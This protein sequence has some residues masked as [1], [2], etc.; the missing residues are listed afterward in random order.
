MNLLFI[1]PGEVGGSEPLL[2]NLARAIAPKVELTVFA[3]RGFSHAYPRLADEAEIVE[4]PWTRSA[5]GLR[6]ASEN[7]WL[8]AQTRRRKLNLVHHGGGTAPILRNGATAVTVHD[9]QYFHYP[10]NFVKVKRTWLEFAVPRAVKK[11]NAVCVPSD[12]VRTD[13]IQNLG[14]DGRRVH[15]IPFGRESLF[16]EEPSSAQDVAA[17]YHLERPYFYYPARTYPHKNHRML[18]E[19]FAPLADRAD[20]ILTG[21]PWFR[22]TSIESAVRNA[23]LG[24]KVR[25]LG[26]VPRRDLAGLY[27][28]SLALVFPSSFEGFGAPLVEAFSL[29]TPVIASDVTSIPEVAG[30]A[31]ILLPPDDPEAW[32]ESMD[33]LIEDP[34]LRR[35]LSRRGLER[36]EAFSWERSAGLQ[37]D[38][39]IEALQT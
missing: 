17:R 18:V 24:G 38:A 30:E 23:G 9:I 19:A 14:A 15:V 3:L 33:K 5:Q 7:S 8:A 39:Y 34:S 1:V 31:A 35:E 12:W 6:I 2:T 37:L 4:V 13:L 26:R 28:G 11:S 25:H 36:A 22:D 32:T 21:A 27:S 16:G 10:E 20:L 29:G